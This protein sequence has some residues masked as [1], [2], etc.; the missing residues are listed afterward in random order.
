MADTPQSAS[1]AWLELP[2]GRRHPIAADCVIGRGVQSDLRL[3]EERVSRR[4]ALIH[5]QGE[6]EYWLVDLGS[7]NGT[8]LNGRR[9]S[10]PVR[11]RDGDEL[12]LGPC[13]LVFHESDVPHLHSPGADTTQVTLMDVRQQTCWLLV[14]DIV[15]STVLAQSMPP[16]ELAVITGRWFHDC[17]GLIEQHGGIVNKYLGDG[18]LAYW[19]DTGGAA[20]ALRA[21]LL[22]LQA[23]QDTGQ[24]AFRLAVHW[25]RLVMGG[26]ATLGEENLAGS[27]VNFVF[28]M[29]KL[30]KALQRRALLSEPARQRLGSLVVSSPVGEHPLPGFSAP[31][32]FHEF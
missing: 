27:E 17:R 5:G 21:A 11:L 18:F 19:T 30:A 20:P 32:L 15:G 10:Q 3:A 13:R 26:A 24:P 7:S 14:A 4:H 16:D 29:D 23:R 2:D 31:F 9:L 12:G 28:R 8:Y 1:P 6:H 22:G 25:G